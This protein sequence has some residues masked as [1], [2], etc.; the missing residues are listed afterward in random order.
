M[1][2]KEK[3]LKIIQDFRKKYALESEDEHVVL[4]IH[5]MSKHSID[6]NASLD[7]T[8]K[9]GGDEGIDGWFLSEDEGSLYVYQSKFSESKTLVLSGLNDLNRGVLWLEKVIVD[10][11]VD[12]IPK[13]PVLYNLYTVLSQSKDRIRKIVFILVSL[14]DTNE[15]EDLPECDELKRTLIN[16]RLMN[17]MKNIN[18]KIDFVIEEYSSDPSLPT[19]VKKYE[20]EAIDKSLINL[21]K[22]SYLSL[23]YI[24]LFDL[25][26]LYRQRGYLLFDKN[27]RLSLVGTKKAREKLVHPLEN[28]FDAICNGTISPEIFP[29]Y[30]GGVT[31]AAKTNTSTDIQLLSLEEPCIING[32]QTIVIADDYLHR[33]ERIADAQALSNFKRIRVIAKIVIGTS[34]DE[35]REITNCNNRQ[36]PIENWQLF[37]NDPIHIEIEYILK[38]Y[39]IFYERQEGRFDTLMKRTDVARLYPNTNNTYVEIFNLGQVVCLCRKNLQWSAKPSEIFLNKRNHDSIFDNYVPKC[40]YDII[41]LR[42]LFL[43]CRRALTN[44]LSLQIHAASESTQKIFSK[45]IVKASIYYIAVI[46]MY[47]TEEKLSLLCE[48]S[49]RLNKIAP[50]PLVDE[51]E[52]FYRRVV[53]KTRDWY[54][55]ESKNLSVNVSSKRLDEYLNGL[56]IEYRI[57]LDEGRLPF[58][59]R[60]IDWSRYDEDNR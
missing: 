16:S 43:A 36:N 12:K 51:F 45:P 3:L 8:S 2:P 52:S 57:S 34:N 35:L 24:S 55:E 32:C 46:Y 41:L 10:G 50:P 29:F 47:Q 14:F 38:E 26:L 13:N 17:H 6:K 53:A 23:A 27:I 31:I 60:S 5:L 37:S 25:V 1:V 7:Q 22:N 15:L 44:Y 39:G 40:P 58:S 11:K 21:R 4:S 9:G 59:S 18:G 54:L 48:Y 49:K 42:N 19:S 56:C 28:T 30:H 33:L 20:I